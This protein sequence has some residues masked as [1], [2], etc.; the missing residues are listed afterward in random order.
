MRRPAASSQPQHRLP[1]AFCL[2]CRHKPL[3]TRQEPANAR[4]SSVAVFCGA[5]PG[6]RPVFSEAAAALGR[7][8]AQADI[9]RL[10]EVI[11]GVPAVPQRL[12]VLHTAPGGASALL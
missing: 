1:I 5:Q 2:Q 4:N 12:A 7:G 10:Y 6:N 11:E 8:L 3:R 9:R